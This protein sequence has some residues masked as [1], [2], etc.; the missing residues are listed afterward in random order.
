MRRWIWRPEEFSDLSGKEIAAINGPEIK[1]LE[2]KATS[3]Q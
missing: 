1:R 3:A 2:Q